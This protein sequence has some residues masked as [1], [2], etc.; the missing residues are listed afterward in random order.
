MKTLSLAALAAASILCTGEAAAQQ[1]GGPRATEVIVVNARTDAV[2]QFTLTDPNGQ[3]MA[4]LKNPLPGGKQA[5]FR[6]R[7]G[8]APCQLTVNATFGDGSSIDGETVDVCKDKTIRF[9]D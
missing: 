7:Q 3:A 2:S 9:T 8:G 4:Q 6:F 1:R 5:R